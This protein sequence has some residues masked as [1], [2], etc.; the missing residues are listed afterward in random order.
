MEINDVIKNL[1][2]FSTRSPKYFGSFLI[3]IILNRYPTSGNV[4]KISESDLLKKIEAGTSLIRI[5]DG[6][7][8]LMTGR[9][10]HFQKYQS[11]IK[12][13][14]NKIV[15]LY[16]ANS[17]YVLAIP[18][19]AIEETEHELN[20]RGRK[21]IWRLFRILFKDFPKDVSYYDAVTFYHSGK[22]E[23]LLNAIP[24]DKEIILVTSAKN[25]TVELQN[26]FKEHE[27]QYQYLTTPE[28]DTFTEYKAIKSELITKTT[29]PVT[30]LTACGPAGKIL[31]YEL[32]VENNIQCIDIGHGIEI[33][34][35]NA[36]Y[37]NRL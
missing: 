19:F 7:A 20:I 14:L 10:I 17:P 24:K 5:G 30:I 27:R 36:D 32:S 22:F 23:K 6:E 1:A 3:S 37:S 4:N 35:K 15:T 13:T 21:R 9:S 8:M 26:F 2:F 31:A 33:I 11:K 28:K 25:I 16:S 18:H 12:T 29:K 34:G